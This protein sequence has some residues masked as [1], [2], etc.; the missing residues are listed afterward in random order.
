MAW[1]SLLYSCVAASCLLVT[2]SKRRLCVLFILHFLAA[3]C[4]ERNTMQ[5]EVYHNPVTDHSRH[6]RCFC[7]YVFRL[8]LVVFRQSI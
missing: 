3:N 8:K 6:D 7:C 5:A 1:V 4:C 2:Q